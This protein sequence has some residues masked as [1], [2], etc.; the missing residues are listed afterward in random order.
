MR[1]DSKMALKYFK[2]I[3][4]ARRGLVLVDRSDLW[5]GKPHKFLTEPLGTSF[6]RNNNGRITCRHIGG[7]AKRMYRRVDFKR[8]RKGDFAVV[9]RIEYDPNR[10]AY[11]ALIK[12]ADDEL[13]YIIAPQKLSVGDQIVYDD[14]VD[15]KVGNCL[16]LKNIPVGTIVHNIEM[17]P[18]KGFQIARSAGTYASIVGRDDGFV[19]IKMSSGEVRR[20]HEDC[21]AV[22]GIVS[23]VDHKNEKFGKAGRIRL[24]GVRPTVRGVAMNPVD[25]PHGGGEGK[26]AAGRHPVSFSGVPTK[27]Y[28]TRNKKKHSSKYIL[29]RRNDRKR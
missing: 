4:P 12:Y 2:P 26:T 23:N 22:I 29:T 17:K 24:K 20:I 21:R 11:I 8:M 10:T 15:I 6:G 28:K 18:M 1:V 7:G 27:G 19:V 9:Q 14:N 25:H 3:S 13:S 5:K 16:P